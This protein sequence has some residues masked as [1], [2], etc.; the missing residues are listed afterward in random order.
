MALT[1]D[2]LMHAVVAQVQMASAATTDWSTGTR[3]LAGV[4]ELPS[5]YKGVL[6]DQYGC[7]HDGQ[8]PYPGAVQAVRCLA[9]RGCSILI[10]SNSSRREWNKI[11][12]ACFLDTEQSEAALLSSVTHDHVG[13]CRQQLMGPGRRFGWRAR[14]DSWARF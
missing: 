3:L 13:G 7:L 4:S 10:L 1:G 11:L 9:Q 5:R 12:A 8:K 14:Q 6:L 2:D